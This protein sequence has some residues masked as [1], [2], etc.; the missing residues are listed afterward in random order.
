MIKSQKQNSQ[1]PGS[2]FAYRPSTC[3]QH[4]YQIHRYYENVDLN[5]SEERNQP[6]SATYYSSKMKSK[7][8]PT[9]V[10][11]TINNSAFIP[12][13]FTYLTKERILKLTDAEISEY[14]HKIQNTSNLTESSGYLFMQSQEIS[15][16]SHLNCFKRVPKK[17]KYQNNATKLASD[18]F[19]YYKNPSKAKQKNNSFSLAKQKHSF[20]NERNK[21][22]IPN[23]DKTDPIR[24][25]QKEDTINDVK[26]LAINP[27]PE[28]FG[29]NPV[30]DYNSE[31]AK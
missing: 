4:E 6:S 28:I 13:N 23:V 5:S 25:V 24:E 12:P 9:S 20:F 10:K 30:Q 21:M 1:S 3:S 31:I 22:S 14:I 2:A 26:V 16:P 11:N 18:L 17:S 19:S 7:L 29:Q 27:T 8:N 15:S